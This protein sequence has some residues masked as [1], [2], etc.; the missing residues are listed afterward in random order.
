MSNLIKRAKPDT[1]AESTSDQ[2]SAQPFVV[3]YTN[4]NSI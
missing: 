4:T 2:L 3:S 1:S